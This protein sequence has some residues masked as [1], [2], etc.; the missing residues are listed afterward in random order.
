MTFGE[1]VAQAGPVWA[2]AGLLFAGGL[3]VVALAVVTAWRPTYGIVAAVAIV[4]ALFLLLVGPRLPQ[5]FLGALAVI[6]ILYAFLGRGIAYLGV[7]PIYI[8]EMVLG[9]GVLALV[10]SLTRLRIGII[11]V[12]LLGFMAWGAARTIPYIPIDGVDA[13]RDGVL[14]GYAAFAIAISACLR[15]AHV[16]KLVALYGRLL[17]VFLMWVPI[18]A[19]ATLR[20][21]SVI[22]SLPGAPV[23]VIY[24]KG[25]DM[26]VHLAGAA[27]FLL[28]GLYSSS[29]V[30]QRVNDVV[31]WVF[32][33]VSV[34]VSAAINRG[35]MLAASVG[36]A[37]LL[38][39]PNFARFVKPVIAVLLLLSV[40]IVV[41]PE[42]DLG[43][44]RPVS[45][46]QL[47][48]NFTSVVNIQ[49]APSDLQG[50]VAWREAWWNTIIN[51]TF[52][53]PYF[54]QGK[55]FGINLATADG[56]QLD[57]V[58]QSLRAPHNGH[59]DILA[60][61]GVVGFG[62]WVLFLITFGIGMIRA[63]LAARAR[64]DL[65]W[66][67][68]TAWIFAYWL[69][70]VVNAT[71]DVYLEGPQ[72]GIWFWALT[73]IG[74]VVMRAARATE[75]E[76]NAPETARPTEPATQPAAA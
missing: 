15:P 14:W 44:A 54:W 26:G 64:G 60:R 50:T 9:L 12:L 68:V 2:R 65:F 42:V 16:R 51:Y 46:S 35:G 38:F 43:G 58:G 30:R 34:G 69:A 1:R 76:P 20:L 39:L 4:G 6:L 67:G 48:D 47:V 61:S 49:S 62:L 33:L 8:G 59:L 57:P 21:S 29:G 23:P 63:A 53:G 55:G 66:A 11:H 31:M 71:F 28:L 24:F 75:G 22:P 18:A 70:S 52:H 5:L 27:A 7:S 25:G 56:F 32:W 3:A 13:L 45:L 36:G 74:L 17:P 19:F 72:G 37:A 73:G 41:N 40:L 10:V